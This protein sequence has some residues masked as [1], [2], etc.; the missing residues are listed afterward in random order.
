MPAGVCPPG[1]NCKPPRSQGTKD[2][3]IGNRYKRRTH[4]DESENGSSEKP[5]LAV[6]DI[7]HHM[8][9]KGHFL[10]SGRA[11]AI[12]TERKTRID[13]YPFHGQP[14]WA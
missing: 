8:C 12:H 1:D 11:Y 4:T 7:S 13:V 2:L 10:A 5:L 3:V 6:S 9:Q 14:K